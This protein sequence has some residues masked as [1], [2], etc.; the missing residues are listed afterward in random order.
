METWLSLRKKKI[1]KFESTLISQE[2]NI[3]TRGRHRETNKFSSP[4][5]VYRKIKQRRKSLV[6]RVFYLFLDV[7]R[8]PRSLFLRAYTIWITAHFVSLF[9]LILSPCYTTIHRPTQYG[10]SEWITILYQRNEDGINKRE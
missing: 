6:P 4:P 7:E 8:T 2:K 1:G 10:N 3:Y 9:H 5:I